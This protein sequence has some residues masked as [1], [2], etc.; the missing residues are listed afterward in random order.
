MNFQQTTKRILV[1]TLALVLALSCVA[2]S[3]CDTREE[4]FEWTFDL[5]TNQDA[6]VAN[7]YGKYMGEEVIIPAMH[8]GLPVEGVYFS[9]FKGAPNLKR[10]VVEGSQEANSKF[11]FGSSSFQ[12]CRALESVEI[13]RTGEVVLGG[14]CFA[15]CPSLS[16]FTVENASKLSIGYYSFEY[17]GDLTVNVNGAELSIDGT[18]F[19]EPF[20]DIHYNFTNCTGQ[21]NGNCTTA[22]LVG[23]TFSLISGSAQTLV[24]DNTQFLQE[25]MYYRA[26]NATFRNTVVFNNNYKEN[27][28]S[29][30]GG[31]LETLVIESVG[32]GSSYS[33]KTGDK[34]YP[35]ARTITIGNDVTYIPAGLSGD[36]SLE[37]LEWLDNRQLTFVYNG[38]SAQ[39]KRL[40]FD[41]THNNNFAYNVYKIN[42]TDGQP[43][44]LTFVDEQGNTL[45]TQSTTIGASLSQETL[46]FPNTTLVPGKMVLGLFADEQM[47]QPIKAN[48]TFDGDTTIHVLLEKQSVLCQANLTLAEGS[49][50]DQ[51]VPGVHFSHTT[52]VENPVTVEMLLASFQP[53]K[54]AE[55][56]LFDDEFC[57][58][59]LARTINTVGDNLVFAKVTSWDGTTTN[60]FSIH[61]FVKDV[62][63]VDFVVDGQ[64]YDTGKVVQGDNKDFPQD[65]TKQGHTF[66]G[67]SVDGTQDGILTQPY[68]PFESQQLTAVFQIN[69]YTVTIAGTDY[70]FQVEWNQKVELPLLEK[71]HYTFLGYSY[72]GTRVTAS[73]FTD[74][75]TGITHCV[76]PYY[77][78]EHDMQLTPDFLAISYSVVLINGDDVQTVRYTVDDESFALEDATKQYHDFLGWYTEENGGGSKVESIDTSSPSWISLYAHFA[79]T[80][81]TVRFVDGDNVVSTQTF[82]CNEQNIQEP[83]VP[84]KDGYL[85]DWENWHLE[86]KDFDV[87]ATHTPKEYKLELSY[88]GDTLDYPTTYTV[89]DN[90]IVLPIPNY[91]WHQFLGW[92]TEENGGGS[93]IDVI[94]TS[95]MQNY[96]LFAHYAPATYTVRFLDGEQVVQTSTFNYDNREVV[97]PEVPQKEGYVS[98]WPEFTIG[99]KNIDVQIVRTPIEYTITYLNTKDMPSLNPTTYT[100]ED[101]IVL[102]GQAVEHY[103]WAGWQNE[104]GETIQIINKGTTGNLTFTAQWVVHKYSVFV[105][106]SQ[107]TYTEHKVEYNKEFNFD[108]LETPTTDDK[109]FV[110]WFNNDYT[111]EYTGKITVTSDVQ[112]FAKWYDSSSIA[113]LEDFEKI[114]QDPTGTFHLTADVD[115]RGELVSPIA[116]FKGVLD[117]MG[118]KLYNF[119]LKVNAS[120]GSFGL[121]NKNS[122]TIRNLTLDEVVCSVTTSPTSDGDNDY[123]GVLVGTNS[124]TIAN[125]HVFSPNFTVTTDFQHANMRYYFHI[126]GLVGKNSGSVANCSTAVTFTGVF[127]PHNNTNYYGTYYC[128][129]YPRVGGLVGTNSGT[130]ANSNSNST[131]KCTGNAY[132]NG[133]GHGFTCLYVG[134]LVGVNDGNSTIEQCHT[135]TS[136]TASAN[137]S[138]QNSMGDIYVGGFVGTTSGIIKE[139]YGVGDVSAY[140]GR[141][142]HV[143]GFAGTVG[144]NSSITNCYTTTAVNCSSA[145][146][147]GGFVG[148]LSG[149]IQNSYSTGNVSVNA[150]SHAAG[151]VGVINA[152][153]TANKSFTTSNVTASTSSAGYFRSS[154][155]SGTGIIVNCYYS[156]SSIVTHKGTALD[157]AEED[158]AKRDY[159]SN[160]TNKEFLQGKMY[161][162]PEYWIYTTNMPVLRW[163]I[164][165][166]GTDFTNGT[167]YKCTTCGTEFLNST[168]SQLPTIYF[169]T[170]VSCTSDA[171]RYFGCNN[172]N[173][174]FAVVTQQATGHNYA[175]D[176]AGKD[177]CTS[178]VLV[179]YTC[180]NPGCNHTYTKQF[181][182]TGHVHNHSDDC[183]GCGYVLVEETCTQ[184]GSV[185]FVCDDCH[186]TVT[187]VLPAQHVW[188]FESWQQQPTCLENGTAHFAC[189]RCAENGTM[190]GKMEEVENSR[191]GHL[192]LTGDGI[193]D[194][195][196]CGLLIYDATN[197]IEISTVEQLK[198]IGANF[199]N[200]SL[201]KTYVLMADLDLTNVVWQPIG[202]QQHPFTG[203]LL[204]NGHKI[205][206]VPLVSSDATLS[207]G[208]LFGYNAGVISNLT[209]SYNN[210]T[211]LCSN[212]NLTFG[213]IASYN[214]G[215]INQCQ[216]VGSVEFAFLAKA[217]VN[218]NGKSASASQTVTIGLLAG[219][220]QG[221][222]VGCTVSANY[223]YIAECYAFM[224]QEIGHFEPG[225][226]TSGDYKNMN[227]TASQ[228]VLAGAV[229]GKNEMSVTNCT[230]SGTGN[231]YN[232]Q[233][234]SQFVEGKYG[235]LKATSTQ[236]FG[237]IAGNQSLVGTTNN[238]VTGKVT[239]SNQAGSYTPVAGN[240]PGNNF[241]GMSCSTTVTIHD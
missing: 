150:G 80:T 216:V 226:M 63:T 117:G 230:V 240:D 194:R 239:Y 139:C 40:P 156:A 52:T 176:G 198:A 184:D 99:P 93:K 207:Y 82:N 143:G 130:I 67:W 234:L 39:F 215:T 102:F 109:I 75:E 191:L 87:H 79:P 125:C 211:A 218:E 107:S 148:V 90:D 138:G 238:A 69:V 132:G 195:E 5:N 96:K 73:I 205:I 28:I 92:F 124:G 77:N 45:A 204:G 44:T 169:D 136:I 131:I 34:Y 88:Q 128:E 53:S 68:V 172:C 120:I 227:V 55:W 145:T 173:K 181:Q 114:R 135:T 229:V 12:D 9:A 193:C 62:F 199:N 209:I 58:T 2:L 144:A 190:T 7:C 165:T 187:K 220:N 222:V 134:G 104:K 221:F 37:E 122:G 22:N 24:L 127:T 6:Y 20:G 21:L 232:Y 168:S 203:V 196:T 70:S 183:I 103:D 164:D 206:N 161:F 158:G 16:T 83:D 213:A 140:A 115:M 182:A 223:T 224:G 57:T 10:L 155:S 159:L 225:L 98:S 95:T 235:F 3:A 147:V 179:T 146:Y 17:D 154:T 153:G 192:D 72:Q 166:D 43:A 152:G 108:A 8:E 18:A 51:S 129:V 186:Q 36:Y 41:P 188:Q 59:P 91:A 32:E 71:D 236:T 47:Q 78:Y 49:L 46:Q 177:F 84:Q 4:V 23:C 15:S 121:F 31:L 189:S 174:H 65:P 105:Y 210:Y 160:F 60:V 123:V 97:A 178:D 19:V 27:W 163:E 56:Q 241:Y 33:Q 35:L 25:D 118:H 113:T 175:N 76:I 214:S 217:E 111:T 13:Y 208:G 157:R 42:S 1:L 185:T 202:T 162:Y 66:L 110:G 11:S 100:V 171:I 231:V 200:D 54:Y 133:K 219:V 29:K 94:D 116:E 201:A 212:K 26:V 167:Y 137:H 85:S 89:E 233:A 106:T 170:P 86:M 50:F 30:N 237:T 151:F 61:V 141:T 197:A 38:S 228:A 126:G 14:S 142:A 101:E 48:T 81:Y 64:I 149:T 180:Q 74:V 112:V 119:T